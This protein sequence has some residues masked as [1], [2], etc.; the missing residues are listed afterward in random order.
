M[1]AARM[2]QGHT[3]PLPPYSRQLEHPELDP[4]HQA[5][6]QAPQ[7]RRMRRQQYVTVCGCTGSV[8]IA[9]WLQC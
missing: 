6:R 7:R 4:T 5:R 8:S 9:E 1:T 2:P 3:S